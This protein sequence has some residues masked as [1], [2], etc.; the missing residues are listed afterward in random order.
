[1]LDEWRSVR[2]DVDTSPIAISSR[3]QRLARYLV[4]ELDAVAAEFG[5][6]TKGDFDTLA[7][8]R[9]MSPA[10]ELSPTRLAEAAL[11]TTGGMTSRIDRLE[12]AG[13]VERRADPTDRRALLIR[14]TDAG[15]VI[16]D[17]VLESNLVHQRRLV[18]SLDA[19]D[20]ESLQGHL[21]TLLLHYGDG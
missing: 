15:R 10:H 13:L 9:R 2:P 19:K 21:R 17:D 5:L 8:L 3:I 1:M 11:I 4:E 7:A 18:A 6:S 16:V 14:L 12:E 20:R